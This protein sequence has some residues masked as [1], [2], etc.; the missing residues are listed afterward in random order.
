MPQ[1]SSR[2]YRVGDLVEN[3]ET[4]ILGLV[5]VKTKWNNSSVIDDAGFK[6]YYR[7]WWLNDAAGYRES[8]VSPRDAR[9]RVASKTRDA[10][11]RREKG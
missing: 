4:G 5:M 1:R 11:S 9:I 10:R 8:L 2:N 7:V 3:C 6:V